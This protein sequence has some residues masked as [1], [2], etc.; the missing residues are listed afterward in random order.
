MLL[1]RCQCCSTADYLVLAP[2]HTSAVFHGVGRYEVTCPISH[3][4]Y[5]MEWAA[6]QCLGS[7]SLVFVIMMRSHTLL[8][9]KARIL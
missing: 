6:E 7:P 2:D 5:V 9:L 4:T 1:W 8:G 3:G